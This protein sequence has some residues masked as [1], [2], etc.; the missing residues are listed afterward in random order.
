MS[1]AYGICYGREEDIKT[2]READRVADARMYEKKHE[3][4]G[5]AR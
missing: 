3:M 1:T 2:V 4:K 5:I